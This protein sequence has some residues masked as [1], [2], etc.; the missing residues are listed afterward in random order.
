ME[1]YSP[2]SPKA[3]PT[4]PCGGDSRA[5]PLTSEYKTKSV[6]KFAFGCSP[7]AP[8]DVDAYLYNEASESAP[9]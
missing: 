7:T 3:V 9:Q 1:G 5:T 8:I 2:V 6:F 4:P